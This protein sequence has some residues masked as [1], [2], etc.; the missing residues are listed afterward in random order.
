MSSITWA[1][2]GD[3]G[4]IAELNGWSAQVHDCDGHELSH[5]AGTPFL[6]WV[7]PVLKGGKVAEGYTASPETG[8]QEAETHLRRFAVKPAP[9]DPTVW[10]APDFGWWCGWCG[11]EDYRPGEDSL[12]GA[13]RHA[14]THDG[15]TIGRL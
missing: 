14:A 11:G 7:E 8:R 5:P 1:P 9:K 12:A 15:T 10:W 4:E 3:Y 2:H 6:W 13:E